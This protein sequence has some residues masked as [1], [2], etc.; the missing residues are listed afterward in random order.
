VVVL[1]FDR[2]RGMRPVMTGEQL[3]QLAEYG[4]QRQAGAGLW[5]EPEHGAEG[6]CQ[7]DKGDVVVPA[8][9]GTPSKWSRPSGTLVELH[10]THTARA[11]TVR[12]GPGGALDAASVLAPGRGA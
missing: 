7:H 6:L 8:D 9:E 11:G 4:V 3:L 2:M 5:V 12:L 10:P 1:R